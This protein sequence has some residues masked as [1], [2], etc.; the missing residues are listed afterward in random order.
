M[1]NGFTFEQVMALLTL[2]L[3]GMGSLYVVAQGL[4]GWVERKFKER[5]DSWTSEKKDMAQA[6]A[7]QIKT[8]I[9][10]MKEDREI[11]AQAFE[12]VNGKISERI[13]ESDYHREQQRVDQRLEKAFASIETLASSIRHRLDSMSQT[14]TTQVNLR[15]AQSGEIK[16]LHE[17][18]KT[19]IGLLR[20]PSSPA[21]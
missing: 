21:E 1:N 5:D 3:G 8:V 11:A 7:D 14:L 6:F 10:Q 13:E 20:P 16:N 12:K 17:Q 9:T 4:R 15:D 18:Q 19:I 2:I